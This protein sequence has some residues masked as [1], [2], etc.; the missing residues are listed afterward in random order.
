MFEF[1]I[2]NITETII[3]EILLKIKLI[4]NIYASY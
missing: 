4:L 1:E 3:A 2:T